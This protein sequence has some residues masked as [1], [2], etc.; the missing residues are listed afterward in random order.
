MCWQAIPTGSD[1]YVIKTDADGNAEWEKTF[2]GSGYDEAA[3]IQPT[4]DC[5]YIVVG[6]YNGDDFYL[7][8]TDG[9]GNID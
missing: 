2:G 6:S 4:D 3:A 1:A 9:E 5:G 8:K 7:I